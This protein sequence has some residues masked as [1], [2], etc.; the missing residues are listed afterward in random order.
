MKL[1]Y[2]EAGWFDISLQK[3][4][5]AR[6]SYLTFPFGDIG[7]LLYNAFHYNAPGSVLFDGEG[8][9]SFLVYNNNTLEQWDCESGKKHIVSVNTKSLVET[10][11]PIFGIQMIYLYWGANILNFNSCIPHLDFYGV[12][13]ENEDDPEYMTYIIHNKTNVKHDYHLKK[14]EQ[15]IHLLTSILSLSSSVKSMQKG[16]FNDYENENIILLRTFL[17][18][19]NIKN[20]FKTIKNTLN[21][22]VTGQFNQ[23]HGLWDN[24]CIPSDKPL[25]IFLGL[26]AL[27]NLYCMSEVNT[28]KRNENLNN[29][30]NKVLKENSLKEYSFL[31]EH[32]CKKRNEIFQ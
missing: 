17:K 31:L 30:V 20:D 23:I 28:Q 2:P 7:K 3:K 22:I 10:Y 6:V 1:E 25:L 9:D 21:S 11:I 26:Y 8:Q 32:C 4:Y 19:I 13:K 5:S 29:I 12:T 16:I 24:G 18:H 15:S 14:I 27:Y